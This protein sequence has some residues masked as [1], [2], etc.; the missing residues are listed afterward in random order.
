MAEVGIMPPPE[1]VTPDFHTQ[2]SLQTTL[3]I[4]FGVTFAL[5]TISVILRLYTALAIVKKL[6]WDILFIVA[7]WGT[8]LAFYIGTIIA[9]P[10]GFGRHIW[11]VTPTQLLGYYNVLLLLAITY[12]WPP[13][14]TKLALLVLY[15]RLNPSKP[16]RACV[17]ISGFLI[18]TFTVVFTILFAG[19]CNPLSVG[20]GVCLNNIA[21][22]QAV[23]NIVFDV[24]II[25]LPIPMVH[26]LQLPLK[27]KAVIGFLIALGSAVVIV[28]IARVAYVRAMI[29]N[30]DVTWTQA[31]AAV[32]STL[33]LN[34][35]IIGNC[36]SRLKPMVQKHAPSW[37][38][39]GS[40]SN[41]PGSYARNQGSNV[42]RSWG[43]SKGNQGYKLESID[44][45][46]K[47]GDAERGVDKD[48]YVINDYRVEYDT[49]ESGQAKPVRTGSTESILAP[50][51]DARRVV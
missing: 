6:D 1:G 20:S 46:D 14:L 24:V 48:I 28:S 7:A 16:F 32:L 50:E 4:L 22:S 36:I 12:I 33:E 17:Y 18:F 49:K 37:I 47:S 26:K 42:P 29:A 11:D 2:T 38:S 34:I 23:L 25:V 19:P 44:R 21:I 27:Q 51:R 13:S 9:I 31:S 3:I 8:S 5:A 39:S 10:A 30:P 45:G 41:A 15:I 43:T 35:G 40:N